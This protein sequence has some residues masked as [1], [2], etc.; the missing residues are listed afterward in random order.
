MEIDL[1]R[2][3]KKE[4]ESEWEEERD[5]KIDVGSKTIVGLVS[6]IIACLLQKSFL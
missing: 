2:E 1:E 5:K 6:C 3:R 4:R